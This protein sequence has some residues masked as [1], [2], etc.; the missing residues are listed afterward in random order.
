M[1][2]PTNFGCSTL[3]SVAMITENARQPRGHMPR[4]LDI[5]NLD[6]AS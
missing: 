4:H 5:Q 1:G 2:Y 6:S 3:N